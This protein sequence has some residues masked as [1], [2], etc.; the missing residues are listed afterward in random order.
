MHCKIIIFK[1]L[2]GKVY[3]IL[4]YLREETYF[5]K[6]FKALPVPSNY[7]HFSNVFNHSLSTDDKNTINTFR[8]GTNKR[9]RTR[10]ECVMKLFSY[11]CSFETHSFIVRLDMSNFDLHKKIESSMNVTL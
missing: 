6:I 9:Y 1:Y 2:D 4:Y 8:F 3:F 7:K 5:S 11:V 10:Y